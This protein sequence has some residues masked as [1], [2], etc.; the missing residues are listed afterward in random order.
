[1]AWHASHAITFEEY[2]AEMKRIGAFGDMKV[3]REWVSQV[4]DCK[5]GD[6]LREVRRAAQA[7]KL[8]MGW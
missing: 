4:S 2:N 1:M 5:R 3:L 8:L 6:C 7:T